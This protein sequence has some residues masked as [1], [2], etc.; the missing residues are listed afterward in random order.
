MDMSY[1]KKQTVSS[2]L[3]PNFEWSKPERRDQAGKLGIIGGNKQGFVATA[4]AYSVA[5][6]AG[7][8]SARVLLPD[9]L[10]STV[11]T[12]QPGTVF[13]PSNPSGGFSGDA[14]NDMKVLSEWS[15]GIVLIG[16]AGNNSET[17]LGYV[18]FIESYQGPLTITRDS[19]DL[20][21]NSPETI[22]NRDATI[23]IASF[24]QLQKLFQATYYPIVVTFSMQL[25]A[26]VEALH[27]FTITNPAVIMTYHKEHLIIAK[28]GTVITQPWENVMAIWRG[29]VAAKIA[30]YWLWRPSDPLMAAAAGI[31]G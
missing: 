24:S 16:D 10:K 20:V 13:A 19:I 7:V 2:P 11:P 1:W 15:D 22:I 6:K 17:A 28:G 26:L 29:D 8:G 30:S 3:Y 4:N 27:K 18:K 25:L 12:T 5:L 31:C 21:K 9:A 23:I 14:V